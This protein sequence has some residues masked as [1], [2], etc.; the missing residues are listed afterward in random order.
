MDRSRTGARAL[1]VRSWHLGGRSAALSR[2]DLEI[3]K[4]MRMFVFWLAVF[5]PKA[6]LAFL[7]VC[8]LL[9]YAVCR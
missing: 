6:R 2:T 3:I 9:L 5:G 7:G 1:P 4:T 8:G